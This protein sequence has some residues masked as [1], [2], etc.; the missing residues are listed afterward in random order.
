MLLG[1]LTHQLTQ[2]LVPALQGT[3]VALSNLSH[4]LLGWSLDIA[5]SLGEHVKCPLCKK[6]CGI[7]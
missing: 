6:S 3:K 4:Y 5:P 1:F 7:P 2:H